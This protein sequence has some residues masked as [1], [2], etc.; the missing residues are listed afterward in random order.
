MC[1]CVEMCVCM[2]TKTV[3]VRTLGGSRNCIMSSDFLLLLS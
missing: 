2:Y 3:A 1:L